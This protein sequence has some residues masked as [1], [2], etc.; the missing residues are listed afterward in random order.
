M[1]TTT[2][3]SL[4]TQYCTT[5]FIRFSQSVLILAVAEFSKYWF[6]EHGIRM[7]LKPFALTASIK[8]FV[9]LGFPHAVSPPV[10]SS[11]FPMFQPNFILA[12]NCTAVLDIPLASAGIGFVL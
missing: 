10:A 5:S 4:S 11:V 7:A 12:A 3:I 1:F 8:A 2:Y 9:T 6:H